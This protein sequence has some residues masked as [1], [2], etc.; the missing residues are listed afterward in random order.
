VKCTPRNGNRGSGTY[1]DKSVI[2]YSFSMKFK[3]E[4][5]LFKAKEKF[6]PKG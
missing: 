3:T 2:I 1:H 5:D 4:M 6:L